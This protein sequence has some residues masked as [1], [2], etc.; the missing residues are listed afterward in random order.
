M[1]ECYANLAEV[2]EAL[3]VVE[4]QVVKETREAIG[5]QK[6]DLSLVNW[7]ASRRE[8]RT[9]YGEQ[10]TTNAAETRDAGMRDQLAAFEKGSITSVN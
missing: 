2:K 7:E 1:S 10:S 6:G 3:E 4:P 5:T 9:D 8:N